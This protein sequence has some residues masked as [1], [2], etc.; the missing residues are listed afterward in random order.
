[1]V[2]KFSE[3]GTEMRKVLDSVKRLNVQVGAPDIGVVRSGSKLR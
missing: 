1:M 3:A 2:F